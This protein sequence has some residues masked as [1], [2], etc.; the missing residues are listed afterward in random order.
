MFDAVPVVS[1]VVIFLLPSFP[2]C[3]CFP[4]VFPF[5]HFD[6]SFDSSLVTPL[7]RLLHWLCLPGLV[8]WD[9]F[10]FA[11]VPTLFSVDGSWMVVGGPVWYFA[12]HVGGDHDWRK[13]FANE[14]F[15]LGWTWDVCLPCVC[16]NLSMLCVAVRGI[17][18][19]V[20]G[21]LQTCPPTLRLLC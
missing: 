16:E 15:L 20:I 4:S 5:V 14:T 1:S 21:D 12:G 17:E 11:A 2:L 3:V 6:L 10:F 8:C 9:S 7:P 18:G 19:T 13:S